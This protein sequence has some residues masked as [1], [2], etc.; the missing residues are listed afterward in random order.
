M[1]HIEFEIN[2]IPKG[3]GRPRLTTLGGHA[4][5]Y[6]PKNTLEFEREI[7]AAYKLKYPTFQFAPEDYLTVEILIKVPIL[8]SFT[9]KEKE[10]A[11]SGLLL[12]AKKP[13]IDNIIKSIL[14]ALNSVCYPDDKQ[15]VTIIAKKIY[16]DEPGLKI[17][18]AKFT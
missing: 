3:K 4:H 5:A 11:R 13:D 1:S 17:N 2:T 7:A 9:K 6:T 12:P 18:V 16:S 14:D 15:I 8:K 10:Q